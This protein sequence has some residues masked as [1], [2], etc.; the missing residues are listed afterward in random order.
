MSRWIAGFIIAAW[1]AVLW[2]ELPSGWWVL[3]IVPLALAIIRKAPLL[4][5]SMVGASW[6]IIAGQLVVHWQLS[7]QQSYQPHWVDG[8][9]TSLVAGPPPLHF[10]LKL[11]AFDHQPLRWW[12][13]VNL[14]LSWY[15]PSIAVKQGQ[16]LNLQVKLKPAHGLANQG[17]FSYKQWLTSQH[18]QA[19]GYVRSATVKPPVTVS[20]R[21]RLLDQLLELSLPEAR[22]IA[23]LTLGYR[24]LLT[25]ADWQL[26]QQSGTSHLIAISGLHLAMVMSGV[27]L[28]VIQLLKLLPQQRLNL[29]HM[30]LLVAWLAA[31]GFSAMAGFSLPTIRA[32][33]M[34]GVGCLMLG[35]YRYLP[36]GQLWLVSL[37]AVTVVMPMSLLTSSYWLSFAALAMLI[38]MFWRWPLKPHRSLSWQACVVMVRIQLLLSILM[39]PIVA[40]Q[41]GFIAWWAPFINL[42]AVPLVTFVLLP[43]ALIGMLSLALHLP[44]ALTIL[45]FV[46]NI[47]AMSI[48]HLHWFI[49]HYDGVSDVAF[50]GPA[51]WLMLMAVLVLIMLPAVPLR[52][53]AIVVLVIGFSLNVVRRND[54]E[55]WQVNVLDVGQGLSVWIERHHRGILYD[56]GPAY[57]SGFNMADAVIMPLLRHRHIQHID[58][59]FIS[60]P[61]H[62]HDGSVPM[63]RRDIAIGSMVLGPKNCHAGWQ[64]QWQ[65]LRIVAIW[66]PIAPRL[67]DMSKNNRSCVM[68]ISDGHHKIL[69]TGDIEQ[70]AEKRL[71]QRYGRQ[72]HADV[73]LVPHH[74]SNSS[75]SALLLDTVKPQAAVVSDGYLNRWHFP[76]HKVLQRYQQRHIAW[77]DTAKGGQIRITVDRHRM[78]FADYRNDL[79]SRWYQ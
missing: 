43:L 5:G 65:G 16:H 48:S 57:P 18:I 61:D 52:R 13:N 76:R 33:L 67:A 75:S 2:P 29:H 14:R 8:Q 78:V 31:L 20:L 70:P 42:L 10:S 35:Q 73:M 62:D 46:D 17:G 26:T 11:N 12:Q 58:T 50:I 7:D 28:V 39:L 19:S 55:Q 49:A 44:V 79:H 34:A 71:V 1:T 77:W 66:P 36:L 32:L 3:V 74:G 69:L 23:A 38:F 51:C 47:L 59:L 72:L 6:L 53:A 40:Y 22:W 15:E 63:L 25:H 60:H 68:M 9:V 64:T 24:G 37:F 54:N 56:T 27:Y 4:S 30:A 45:T 41:F 21:Q